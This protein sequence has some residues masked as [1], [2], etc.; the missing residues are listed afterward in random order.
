[1]RS[2]GPDADG[3]SQGRPAPAALGL[4]LR[5]SP[6]PGRKACRPWLCPPPRCAGGSFHRAPPPAPHRGHWKDVGAEVAG[7][8]PGRR[9]SER[10]ERSLPASAHPLLR[11]A[12]SGERLEG[13]RG[14]VGTRASGLPHGPPRLGGREAHLGLRDSKLQRPGPATILISE[15]ARSRLCAP[16]TKGLP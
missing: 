10:P 3:G 14:G 8:R 13:R 9:G 4:G 2:R 12:A 1:M 16:R 15:R 6:G 5:A 11:A 7:Q